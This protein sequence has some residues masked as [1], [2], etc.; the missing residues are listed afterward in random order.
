MSS[1]SKNFNSKGKFIKNEKNEE[2]SE[3]RNK[4]NNYVDAKVKRKK[5]STV[6]ISMKQSK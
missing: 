1:K 4:D 2:K 5:E 3:L 6:E